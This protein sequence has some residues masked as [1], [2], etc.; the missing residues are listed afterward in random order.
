MGRHG[1]GFDVIISFY[2]LL[3]GKITASFP[4]SI[5]F[6]NEKGNNISSFSFSFRKK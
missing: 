1:R 3:E 2:V 5:L 6:R 4:V